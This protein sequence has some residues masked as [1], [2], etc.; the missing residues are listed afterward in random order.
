MK[1]LLWAA[2]MIF[3]AV[4]STWAQEAPTSFRFNWESG[5]VSMDMHL[6]DNTWVLDGR[7]LTYTQ[8]L[9]GRASGLLKSSSPFRP[10]VVLSKDQ[11]AHL[12]TLFTALA[13]ESSLSLLPKDYQGSLLGYSLSFGTPPKEVTF[14]AP[15]MQVNQMNRDNPQGTPLPSDTPPAGRLLFKFDALR[16]YLVKIS[17]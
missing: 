12:T 1:K 3:L 10:R 17:S 11:L 15:Q 4:G 5:E 9:S 8:A 14:E 2:L 6:E 13:R 16:D 7:T